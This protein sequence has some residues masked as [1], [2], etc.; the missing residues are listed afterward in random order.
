MKAEILSI[1]S[2][3]T[4]GQNL[5]TN[6]QWLSRRLAEMGVPVGFHTT[7]ADDLADNIAV[8]RTAIERADLV[9]ATGG[10]GPT[11]D[12][13][14]R[15]VIAAVA[16]VELVEDAE[17]LEHIRQLF[18]R[19]NR[20][21]PDRNRVQA[22]FPKGAEPIFNPA[23]TAPGVWMRFGPKV[24][25]AMPGVP[26]EMFRM[27][28]E[29]VKPRLIAAG[30][31]GRGVFV[32]RKINTFGT[33]ESG[34]EEKLLDLTRRGHV[35]EVGI[36]VSDAVIS[37]RILAHGESPDDVRR[38]IEPIEQTIR[39]RLGTL[40][41]GAEQDELEDVVMQLLKE[42]NQTVAMAESLTAGLA[43]FRLATVPGASNHLLG[44]VV[45]YTNAVKVR[46]L[47]VPETLIA[48]HTAVSTH[49]AKAMAE[50]VR[51]KFGTD[52]GVATT[53]YAGPGNADDGTPAGTVFVAVASAKGTRV[54]PFT[55]G[56]T[57]TEIQSRT[58]KQALN[59]LRLELLET[60]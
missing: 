29:L 21:M 46:E 14:T 4:S 18:T 24:I 60:L 8:F 49:V 22:L 11:Q 2:E 32:Q 38:Q 52:Y 13:L 31:G 59:L 23:G 20:E 55:W 45:A 15:E 51:Q 19:R 34:V 56:G 1:G 53:G 48:K 40:V 57:R 12:D 30:F 50:G 26:S 3:I 36:T 35:P 54:Q 7:V 42:R 41:F 47:G 9:I 10:L 37:L 33:G 16:G 5:D 58:A 44:G 39:E 43:A 27:F 6:G 25:A 28:E 17:S